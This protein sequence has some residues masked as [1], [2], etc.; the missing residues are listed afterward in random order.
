MSEIRTFALR[1]PGWRVWLA[2]TLAVVVLV[3]LFVARLAEG[4]EKQEADGS[5]TPP[6]SGS[7]PLTEAPEPSGSP[8]NDDGV[9]G[10]EASTGAQQAAAGAMTV[11]LAFGRAWATPPSATAPDQWWVGVSRH[12]TQALAERLRE[13]DP[14]TLPAT[15]VTGAAQSV[16]GGVTSAEVRVPTDA[17]PLLVVCVLVAGRWVV[18][19]FEL[20]AKPS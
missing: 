13:V 9:I 16:L 15:R 7:T 14:A 1:R 5:G 19:E 3:V 11:A 20:E 4:D 8:L 10:P 2:G 18:A 6:A 17:G 12:T